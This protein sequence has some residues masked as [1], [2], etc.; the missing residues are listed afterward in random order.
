MAQAKLKIENRAV[1]E[2]TPYALNARTHSE[3]QVSQIA[4]SIAAFGFVNPVLLG[5]DNAIIAGHGRVLAARA[6]GMEKVPAIALRHLSEAQAN[7]LRLA[8]NQLAVNAGWDEELLKASLEKII[9]MDGGDDLAALIGFDEEDMKSLLSPSGGPGE[10]DYSGPHTLLTDRFGIV[11]FSVLN[12]R[13]GWWQDRKRAWMAM[14]IVSELGRGNNALTFSGRCHRYRNC[15]KT[16]RRFGYNKKKKG[17]EK[18][19][20]IFDPVLCELAYR[21]FSPPGGLVLD[22]FAGGSV[23]GVVAA[24]LGRAYLGYDLRK[25]QVAANKI[26]AKEVCGGPGADYFGPA[27]AMPKLTPIESHGGHKVKRD[28][29]FSIAG[30]RGGKVRTCWALAQGASGL[31]TAGSRAS[32]QVNI[33]A[34]IAKKLDIPCR[35]HTPEGELSPEVQDA[36]AAGAKVIQ[37]KAG[38]NTVIIARAR[39]DAKAQGFK[40]IPFGME[41]QEAVEQTRKQVANIPKAVKR[42]V[43]P[44]GSGMSL[45]GLLWGIKDFELK[46]SVLAIQVGADP[47]KR[48]NEF[49]PPGWR[50]MVKVVKSK[51]DYHDHAIDTDLGGLPLDPIYEG[52]CIP[53]LKPGDLFWVVGIRKTSVPIVRSLPV[54]RCADA[55]TIDKASAAADFIFSCPPYADLEV[56][57]DDPKDL[58]TLEYSEFKEA[59]R[60]IIAKTCAK[61][62][63]DRFACFVVGEVRGKDGNYYSFVEDTVR[64]FTDAGMA[65]YNEMI[66]VTMVGSLSIR[67]GLQFDVGR[68]IGKTHQNVLVF[69]K[70][71]AKRAVK[72]IGPVEFGEITQEEDDSGEQAP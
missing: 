43:I 29:K 70:G 48:L 69:L 12:A 45:A 35:V 47:L 37:H 60:D 27:D 19:T 40:E 66:L 72:A 57:S 49:A 20:S 64:A 46:C 53:F 15:R 10:F 58:S 24:K 39:D 30:G 63:Q 32:P 7:A 26:Q 36:K 2:L 54:W 33:V 62:K 3:E 55:R 42:V 61:L 18:G 23:R 65:F 28:D 41:C 9:D 6:L 50:K 21:W 51:V 8:D 34:Q 5:E 11:P 16:A 13:E 44:L 14:G 4:A 67:V 59:Y 22:P 56:Y 52:K 68:K 25:E 31:V 71:D 17:P 38:H 1:D